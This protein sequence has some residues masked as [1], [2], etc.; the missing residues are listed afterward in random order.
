M[1]GS[2][3]NPHLQAGSPRLLAFGAGDLLPRAPSL[4]SEEPGPA[5]PTPPPARAQR[6]ARLLCPVGG[7][8][9]LSHRE[10]T[11]GA[12]IWLASEGPPEPEIAG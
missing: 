6:A 11:E 9:I 1:T 7:A 4:R 5:Q 8:P 10:G 12:R 3:P 2:F